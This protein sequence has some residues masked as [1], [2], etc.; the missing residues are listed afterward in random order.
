M[1]VHVLSW[2]LKHSEARLGDRLVLI[3]LA[4]HA[5]DDGTYAWPSQDLIA[6]ESRMS[7]RQVRRCLTA[8]ERNG[9]IIAR[10]V[11]RYGTTIFDVVM[12]AQV[13]DKMSPDKLSGGTNAVEI[14]SDLSDEPSVT[15]RER[16][17]AQVR[18]KIS[19]KP[20]NRESWNLTAQVLAE[21]N[22]Q[23]G[24]KLRL[25]TSAGVAS[26]AAKRV[27]NRVR[28]YPDITPEEHA[29][30]IRRTLASR[31]WGS[32]P[33]AIGVVFGPDVFEENITRPAAPVAA[34]RGDPVKVADVVA[35]GDALIA[36]ALSGRA[37]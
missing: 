19:G 24:R 14:R 2:V 12:A 18:V 7:V 6:H 11:S 10:G 32:G 21:F 36:E 30:I 22:S 37:A 5:K 29:G 16:E 1:S 25:L 8:L 28:A 26:N 9:Q 13:A 31:W 33:P 17:S 15:V 20:V 4:D 35:E 27:Y 23:S 34:R 3:S